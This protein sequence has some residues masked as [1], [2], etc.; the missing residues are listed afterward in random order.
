[1]GLLS[2]FK[3]KKNYLELLVAELKQDKERLIKENEDLK[4]YIKQLQEVTIKEETIKKDKSN[5]LTKLENNILN[6]INRYNP[7]TLNDLVKLSK[8]PKPSLN[9]YL[10]KMRKKGIQID[11]K[12]K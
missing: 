8:I 12:N 5:K 7:Q 3:P 2:I 4:Q 11:Y 1:M 6:I 10:S 9:V